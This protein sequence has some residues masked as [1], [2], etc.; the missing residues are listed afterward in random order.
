MAGSTTGVGTT[1]GLPNYHGELI[2]LTPSDTP[3]LSASGGLSGGKQTDSPAFEWQTYDLRDA[4]SRPRL[5]GADAPTAE[6]RVRG[7]VENVVQI[8]QEAVSTSYTKL[9]ATGQYATPGSAPFYSA[10]GAPNP[11]ANEHSWQVMQS[12]KQIARDVNW[13][14]WN[15]VCLDGHHHR[16]ARPRHR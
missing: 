9:A 5:E 14:M 15:C 3:L 4:A 12:L 10:G 8:F 11:V 13:C 2:A 1:F 7:N 16:D 6:S